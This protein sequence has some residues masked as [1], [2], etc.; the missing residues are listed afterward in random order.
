MD[1]NQGLVRLIANRWWREELRMQFD[2]LVS[3]GNIGL[4]IAIRRFDNSR[5]VKLGTYATWWIKQAIG[6]GIDDDGS[7]VRIPVHMAEKIRKFRR[8]NGGNDGA[9]DDGE[10]KPEAANGNGLNKVLDAIAAS[11]T[12]SLNAPINRRPSADAQ[13]TEVISTMAAEGFSPEEI[14]MRDRALQWLEDMIGLNAGN[15]RN[16]EV[17]VRRMY[18][19]TLQQLGDAFGVTRER[20]RQVITAECKGEL[21]KRLK[22]AGVSP[23]AIFTFKD[24][25]KEGSA[26]EA[27]TS[28]RL[29]TLGVFNE[30][31]RSKAADG[32][33]LAEDRWKADGYLSLIFNAIA[34]MKV[35]G[36]PY[37][38]T[39]SWE[40][41]LLTEGIAR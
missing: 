8:R 31:I 5:R 15:P 3:I 36:K 26:R 24:K 14:Y 28:E 11:R 16:A 2:D 6:R 1:A 12:I 22:K 23:S 38:G 18:G 25:S 33:P 35:G 7:I 17:L 20:I 21:G 9:E 37:A 19:E 29:N 27:E 32:V 39:G 4:L 13:E 30:F 34:G 40:N 41:Y 10:A